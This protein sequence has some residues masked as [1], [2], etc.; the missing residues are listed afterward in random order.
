MIRNRLAGTIA[1]LAGVAL[2]ATACGTPGSSNNSTASG[3]GPIKIALVDAQSGQ[4]A[5]LGAWELKGT[6]LAVNQ[7]NAKGGIDGRKIQLDVYDDQGD[8]TT[9]TT[10]ARKVASRGY[11][12]MFGTAESSVTQAMNPILEQAQIPSITS[13]QSP[14]IA[15][16]GSPF[17]FFNGPTSVTYDDTLADYLV[18][19][20]GYKSYAM[21]SNN[22]SYGTGEHDAF[23]AALDQRG[24]TPTDDKVVT[25]DQK[26]FSSVLTSIRS[27]KPQVLFIGTEEVEAG[28]IAKQAR[29]LGITAV[30]AG[31]APIATPVYVQTAGAKNAEGSIASTPYISNDATPAAQQF[32]AAYRKAYHETAELHGAKAYDGAQIFLNALKATGGKGGQALADQ[33]RSTT[34][35]GL[36]GTFHYDKSGVGI[37]ETQIGMIK[38]GKLVAAKGQ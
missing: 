14:A 18:K 34:Y 22:G 10:L 4:L 11:I 13:G 17:Q 37:H 28:L 9:G 32:A 2:A 21:I 29:E 15:E 36:L 8:P 23:K 25:E 19:T 30:F 27:H 33:I 3:S 7:W 1:A 12:A 26:D 5:S 20:K 38:G 6:K 31:A 24:I 16:L 35:D